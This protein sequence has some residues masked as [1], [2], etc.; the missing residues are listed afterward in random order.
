MSLET[1]ARYRTINARQSENV[2]KIGKEV[3]QNGTKLGNQGTPR[4]GLSRIVL[5]RGIEWAVREQIA[6]AALD[7]GDLPL[8]E[9]RRRIPTTQFDS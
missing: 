6:V 7:T 8:A 9:V 4:T 1:L 3:L 5:I 2:V